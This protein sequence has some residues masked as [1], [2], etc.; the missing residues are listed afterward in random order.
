MQGAVSRERAKGGGAS[1]G[2][3]AILDTLCHRVLRMLE[4]YLS[5]EKPEKFTD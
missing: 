3:W 5:S 4:S 2:A 1:F